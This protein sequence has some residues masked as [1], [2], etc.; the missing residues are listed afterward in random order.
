MPPALP[1]PAFTVVVR[2]YHPQHVDALVERVQRGQITAAEVRAAAFP[3]TWRGYD[4]AGVD[5]YLQQLV[6]HLP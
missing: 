2:G 6:A 3:V 5:A 1:Q 4:R